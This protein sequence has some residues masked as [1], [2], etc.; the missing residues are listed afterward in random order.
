MSNRLTYI[1]DTFSNTLKMLYYRH[2]LNY[3]TFNILLVP[4]KCLVT[5]TKACV[6]LLL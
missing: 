3:I 2:P 6:I 5:Y 1:D 4:V